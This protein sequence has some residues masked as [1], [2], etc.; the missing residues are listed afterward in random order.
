MQ[1]EEP[2]LGWGP[3]FPLCLL[4][5]HAVM[6]RG[7]IFLYLLNKTDMYMELQLVY[8]RAVIL[9]H[10]SLQIFVVMRQNQGNYKLP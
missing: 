6:P 10:S 3:L 8:L 5:Q 4:G 9:I 2:K 7:C 1:K